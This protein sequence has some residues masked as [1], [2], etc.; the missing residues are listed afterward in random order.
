MA[1]GAGAERAQTRVFLLLFCPQVQALF[2]IQ[3]FSNA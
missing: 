3:G 2:A 1:K